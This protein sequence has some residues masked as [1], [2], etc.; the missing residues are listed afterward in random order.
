MARPVRTKKKKIVRKFGSTNGLQYT[1]ARPGRIGAHSGK[2]EPKPSEYKLGQVQ[3]KKLMCCYNVS[4]KQFSN[5][6]RD[7]SQAPD[8][9]EYLIQNLELRLSNIVYRLGLAPTLPAA[10]QL[11]V[12]GHVEVQTKQNW[13]AKQESDDVKVE[14]A[15]VDKPNYRV[16]PGQRIRLSPKYQSK[17]SIQIEESISR[18]QY[19]DYVVFNKDTLTGYISRMP[20]VAEIPVSNQVDIQKI[21]EFCSRRL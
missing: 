2:R 18:A 4:A 19:V 8:T 15:R 5:V 14:F 12:H 1:V 11:V 20:N 17:N 13:R 21:I 10:R 7:A 6:F 16:R 3:T 9:G